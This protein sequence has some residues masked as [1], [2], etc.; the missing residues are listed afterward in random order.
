MAQFGRAPCSG[1]GGR[2][3]ESCRLDYPSYNRYKIYGLLVKGLRRRPLTAETGVRFPYRLL[4]IKYP[5]E[6]IRE[7]LRLRIF[8]SVHR[9][10]RSHTGQKRGAGGADHENMP[11]LS[12][13]D[14]PGSGT[15]PAL[16]FGAG[17]R[18]CAMS[19]GREENPCSCPEKFLNLL[20][21][22]FPERAKLERYG[23]I[24]Q[25]G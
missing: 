6:K 23:S 21:D 8:F 2:K 4:R 20:L 1:R 16:H 18:V 5:D 13:R 14:R 19:W 9:G 17:Q 15:V 11:L 24:A 7:R 12:E 10:A 25:L 22:Y 3:F